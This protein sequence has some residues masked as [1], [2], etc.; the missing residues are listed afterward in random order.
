MKEE[1]DDNDAVISKVGAIIP[2]DDEMETISINNFRDA[3]YF[4][5]RIN[6]HTFLVEQVASV[7]CQWVS[8]FSES[9][10]VSTKY[11]SYKPQIIVAKTSLS[12]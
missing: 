8:Y 10:P 6:L 7:L 5:T 1:L 9:H 3:F 4:A 12:F 11:L 2:L